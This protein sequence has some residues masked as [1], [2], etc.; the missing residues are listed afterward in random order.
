MMTAAVLAGVVDQAR[1]RRPRDVFLLR[2]SVRKAAFATQ[3][4]VGGV[5][6]G[7]FTTV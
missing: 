2:V 1:A 6:V 5:P 4:A 7:Y 3:V